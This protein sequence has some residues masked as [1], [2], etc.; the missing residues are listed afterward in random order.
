VDD[1]AEVDEVVNQIYQK[2]KNLLMLQS[3]ILN[4][5]NSP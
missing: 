1:E 3:K 2:K 4:Q 5:M